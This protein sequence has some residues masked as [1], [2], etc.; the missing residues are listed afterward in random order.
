MAPE[1][2]QMKFGGDIGQTADRSVVRG[3]TKKSENMEIRIITE[4]RC[5][6]NFIKK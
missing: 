4:Q 3:R 1:S 5:D 6:D 2:V